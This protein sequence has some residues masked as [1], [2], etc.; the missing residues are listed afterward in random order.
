MGAAASAQSANIGFASPTPLKILAMGDPQIGCSFGN[1]AV[2]VP[3]AMSDIRTLDHDR[4]VIVGDLVQTDASLYADYQN[5]IVDEATR[6]LLTLAGNSDLIAGLPAYY[7]ATGF[8]DIHDEYIRG[9]RMIF[10]GTTAISPPP[11][12]G[13][14]ICHLGLPQLQELAQML[15]RDPWTTTLLFGHAPV[16]DTTWRSGF[17]PG[18]NEMWLAESEALER[19][20]GTYS[21]VVFYGSG[22][23]HYNYVNVDSLGYDGWHLDTRRGVVH[24]SIGDSC[25][26]NGSTLIEVHPDGIALRVRDH[27]DGNGVWRD[28]LERRYAFPT[29]LD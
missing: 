26:G 21:N 11:P 1:W 20:L 8:P 29:T 6:P 15:R 9:I 17:E 10:M 27:R 4:H 24:H 13:G 23:V 19:L 3:A 16:R 12:G 7:A 2:E 14:H 28:S 18:R 22:H 25:K 5:L